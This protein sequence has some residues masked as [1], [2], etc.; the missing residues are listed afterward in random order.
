MDD[1]KIDEKIQEALLRASDDAVVLKDKVWAGIQENLNKN[2]KGEHKMTKK[3]IL[4]RWGW[5]AAAVILGLAF[6]IGTV[7]GQAAVKKIKELLVP[8]KQITEEIEGQKEKRDVSLNDSEVGYTIY[9]DHNMYR[10]EKV[11]GK[12]RII[13]RTPVPEDAPEVYMEISQVKNE[14]KAELAAKTE[15]ELKNSFNNV[16]N[17]GEVKEPVKGLLLTA[18]EGN[19]WNSKVVNYYFVSSEDRGTFVIKQQLFVEA[20]EGHG[21]RYY[22]MLKE[23]KVMK[24]E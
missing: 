8:Q 20:S 12:D 17:F 13:P 3:S 15:S 19:K 21:A 2:I 16:R 7:P 5:A 24:K 4:G 11:E 1:K 22:N 9:F 6:M 14:T 10:L 23:F 18:Q